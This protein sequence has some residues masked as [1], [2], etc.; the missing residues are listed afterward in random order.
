VTTSVVAERS[1]V[2]RRDLLRLEGLLM[3]ES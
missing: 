2:L 1:L 3:T